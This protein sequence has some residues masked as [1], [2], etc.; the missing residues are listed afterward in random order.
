MRI[1]YLMLA[2]GMALVMAITWNRVG[3]MA[4]GDGAGAV[5]HTNPPGLAWASNRV[6]AGG[7]IAAHG[8]AGQL[9]SNDPV[10][11]AVR[12]GA[13]NWRPVKV[14]EAHA[15]QA[16]ADGVMSI[17]APDGQMIRLR[18]ERHFEHADGNWTWVGREV[19][20]APGAETVLTFGE[21]AVFGLIRHGNSDLRL[22]TE[23]GSVWLVETDGSGFDASR[24]AASA[25]DFLVPDGLPAALASRALG[26]IQ[27]AAVAGGVEL[28][29]TPPATQALAWTPTTVDILVGYTAGFADRLGG[30]SQAQTRLTFLVDLANQ[31]YLRSGLNAQIRL[32]KTLRVDY[33]DAT[34]NDAAL[35]ALTGVYCEPDPNGNVYVPDWRL[36]CTT[37]QRPAALQPLVD[38]RETYG[39]DLLVM[40]RKFEDPENASCGA[41]W[42]L[43]GQQ[44]P[45][46]AGSSGFGVSVVSDSSGDMFPDNAHTCPEL[47]LA[48]E[49]GHNMGQQHDVLTARETDDTDGDGNTLDPEEYGAHPDSFSYSTDG[50]G[51]DMFTIMS[52]RRAGQTQYRVFANPS[53]NTCGNAPCGVVG[54]ADNV[55]SMGQT[56]AA[57]AAFRATQVEFWDVSGDYWAFDAIR[58]LAN[59]DVTQGC[60]TA[61]PLY[62]PDTPVTR[63]QM[64]VF[65]LRGRH[66]GAYIP[67]QVATSRFADVPN[68]FWALSWIEQLAQEGITSGCGMNPLV[69]CPTASVTRDQMA[70]LLLRAKYGAN[71][72]PPPATGVFADVPL[73]H[74]AAPWIE[75]LAA[76]GI[77]D[78]CMTAPKAYCPASAVTRDEMAVFLVRTFGL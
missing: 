33:P 72:V 22:T 65:L 40:V 34:S 1:V 27:S 77:T 36:G 59:A 71:Y 48:H 32:V 23:A 41:A 35:M 66:G 16:I 30:Q 68:G 19:G 67:P 76:D 15:L 49:L 46:D 6:R 14:S 55:R 39:A 26:S 20:A 63:D 18:Y 38:A 54:Q 53:L 29:A 25:R 17:Q 7:G 75:K 5:D 78:G 69:Y 3:G 50:T 57:V 52:I 62:C 37:V 43:G 28:I 60:G 70:V 9:F 8:D 58:R 47:H 11:G 31:A 10:R 2:A 73:S 56:M 64:A 24:V 12:S 44:T 74:W 4:A 51:N 61:P 42:M 21:K 45:I 13:S